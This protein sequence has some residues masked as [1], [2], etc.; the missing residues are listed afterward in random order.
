MFFV[1]VEESNFAFPWKLFKF[2]APLK[3]EREAEIFDCVWEVLDRNFAS[4]TKQV[5]P[6][7][8][9]EDDDSLNVDFREHKF[10]G[11]IIMPFNLWEVIRCLSG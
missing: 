8:Y 6:T 10:I 7:Q 1:G 5:P 3:F 9:T 4:K 2:F 11:D